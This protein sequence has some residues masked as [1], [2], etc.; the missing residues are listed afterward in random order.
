MTPIHFN[1]KYKLL[2]HKYSNYLALVHLHKPIPLSIIYILSYFLYLPYTF[3]LLGLLFS[4]CMAETFLNT[5]SKDTYHVR[6]S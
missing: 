5:S 4:L 1:I 2:K 3:M 6:S